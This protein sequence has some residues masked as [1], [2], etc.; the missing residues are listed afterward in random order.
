MPSALASKAHGIAHAEGGVARPQHRRAEA[1]HDV[2]G[3]LDHLL[4]ARHS[5]GAS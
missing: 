1:Q 3:S 5:S 2:E 4:G